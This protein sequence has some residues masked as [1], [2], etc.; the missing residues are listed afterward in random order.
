MGI[1]DTF[2]SVI[3]GLVTSGH[4]VAARRL[5]LTGYHAQHMVFERFPKPDL[6]R[7]KQYVAAVVMQSVIDALQHPQDAAMVSMF[8]PCE[9]LQ[10]AGITPYSVE[11]LSGYMTGTRAQQVFLDRMNAEGVPETMCSFHRIFLGAAAYGL[12]P[13][14][15]FMIYTNLACDGNMMTFPYLQRKFDVP[16]FFIDVPYEKSPA[17]VAHVASQLREMTDF[18]ENVTGHRI[19]DEALCRQVSRS[20][21]TAANY[22]HYLDGQRE[23]YLTGNLTSEMYAV[24]MNHILLGTGESER[25]SRMLLDDIAHAPSGHGLRLVWLHLIPYMQHAAT[26]LLDFDDRVF[27]T[28]CDLAYESALQPIDGG[29]PYGSMAHRMVYSCYN[30][31]PSERIA[32]ALEVARH[33][34]ADGAV[35]FAH[36]GCKATIG[37]SQLMKDAFEEA[38]LPTLILDGDG[39]DLANNSDGQIATRLEAFFEMLEEARR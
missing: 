11:T 33:T 39:C 31:D 27:I 10:V 15:R 1:V 12:M 25:Y 17:S 20:A 32:Q 6:P 36:W 5:L 28:A 14:P 3:D 22:C 21:R 13:A 38:G 19:S 8:T 4:T 23:H 24:F 30:G 29:D 7:S 37:A 26:E 16:S 18:V 35:I 9:P 2:G 34:G